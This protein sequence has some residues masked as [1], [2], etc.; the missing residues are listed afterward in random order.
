MPKQKTG[1]VRFLCEK[2]GP[3]E[4]EFKSAI[5]PV[6]VEYDVPAAY[7]CLAEYD[8]QDRRVALCLRFAFPALQ[9]EALLQIGEIF[10]A[11]FSGDQQLDLL[12]LDG[13]EESKVQ[14]VAKNFAP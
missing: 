10:K 2:T 9:R 1:E 8:G 3:T 13:K 6:L 11:M 7:L 4:E 12:I 14:R 5:R